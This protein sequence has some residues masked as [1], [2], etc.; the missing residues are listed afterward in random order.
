M[1]EKLK[2]CALWGRIQILVTRHKLVCFLL[3]PWKD[4]GRNKVTICV[5]LKL[6]LLRMCLMSLNETELYILE[7]KKRRWH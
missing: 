2:I 3:I 6:R 4:Q 1:L 7:A 5:L